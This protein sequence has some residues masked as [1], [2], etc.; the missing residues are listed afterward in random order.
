MAKEAIVMCRKDQDSCK[1]FEAGASFILQH[2]LVGLTDVD[3]KRTVKLLESRR[4]QE[5]TRNERL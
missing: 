3:P 5:G 2:S 4:S 1:I